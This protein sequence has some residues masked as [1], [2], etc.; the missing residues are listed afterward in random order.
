M[1]NTLL[2]LHDP[3]AAARYYAEMR[4]KGKQVTPPQMAPSAAPARMSRI[5]ILLGS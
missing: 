3:E 1:T 5:L 4:A 2:T